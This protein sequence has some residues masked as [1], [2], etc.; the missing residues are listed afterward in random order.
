MFPL[1]CNRRS[2]RWC[3][4]RRNAKFF[5]QLDQGVRRLARAGRTFW[6]LTMTFRSK[7]DGED[8][9][10]FLR[11]TKLSQDVVYH[12]YERRKMRGTGYQDIHW[13]VRRYG[14]YA[15]TYLRS[16]WSKSDFA[17]HA[18]AMHKR[19]RKKY[20][21]DGFWYGVLELTQQDVIHMH[22]VM[23]IDEPPNG[24][25][26]ERDWLSITGDSTQIL[27]SHGPS[28]V[29]QMVSYITAYAAKGWTPARDE[30]WL[31]VRRRFGT[32]PLPEIQF[33]AAARIDDKIWNKKEY[34]QKYGRMKYYEDK[35]QHET[36]YSKWCKA[37]QAKDDWLEIWRKM[38]DRDLKWTFYKDDTV[39]Y[40]GVDNDF[41]GGQ[42]YAVW[43]DG[44]VYPVV[45]PQ[46]AGK[47]GVR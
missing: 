16:L 41:F 14:L 5:L 7:R 42:T 19:L 37:C 22:V 2:C 26:L 21:W 20:G 46:R 23:E 47:S 17:K 32:I 28:Q 24:M 11:R 36:E 38:Y 6:L 39:K 45:I 44:Y 27:F 43:D 15:G 10:G 1:G 35:H 4:D 34:K 3:A 40:W 33:N 25:Q 8:W 18:N 31:G 9:E 13:L 12:A 30:D 29:G